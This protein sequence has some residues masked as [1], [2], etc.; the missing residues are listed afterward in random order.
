MKMKTF[1][2]LISLFVFISAQT[3]AQ[4]APGVVRSFA[5]SVNDGYAMADVVEFARNIEW[6]E[7]ATPNGLFFREAFAVAGEFQSNRDFLISGFFSD[8]PE[9]VEKVNAQRSRAGGRNGASLFGD[10][11][12]CGSRSRIQSVIVANPGSIFDETESTALASTVCQ[13]N[14]GTIQDAVARAAAL[15]Q[16]MNA[17]AAVDVRFFG[18]NTIQQGSQVGI[19][20]VFPNAEEFGTAMEILRNEGPNQLDDGITCNGGSLWVSHRIYLAD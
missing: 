10:M 9:M 15:G 7:E 16:Q 17:Y 11:I 13:L 14:G 19:R 1:L 2:P 6:D 8:F 4:D 3:S 12:T 20:F 5:C 18:G